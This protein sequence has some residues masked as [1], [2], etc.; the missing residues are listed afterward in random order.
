[1][2][3]HGISDR[4]TIMKNIVIDWHHFALDKKTCD[5]CNKT[6]KAIIH[7]INHM[8]T[9]LAKK[10]HIVL[11]K[12]IVDDKNISNSNR[13]FING[14]S[15]EKLLPDVQIVHTECNSCGEL[16]KK[17]Q[18]CRAVACNNTVSDSIPFELIVKAIQRAVQ[19]DS[20]SHL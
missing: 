10:A 12:T 1:M 6:E 11:R 13:I 8:S 7:A 19:L 15:L 17:V 20:D 4:E 18:Y 5:R 3:I 2:E 16:T 9:D 14:T